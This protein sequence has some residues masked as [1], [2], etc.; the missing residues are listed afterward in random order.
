MKLISAILIDDELSCL[1][2]LQSELGKSCPE[3]KVHAL[4]QSAKEGLI[5]FNKIKPDLIFLDIDM[6]MIDGFE[7]L[8][9]LPPSH[10]ADIIFVTAFNDFAIKA[11]RVSAADY[12]LKPINSS[13]LKEALARIKAKNAA[14]QITDFDFL[15][16]QIKNLKGNGITKIALPTFNGISMVKI[17]EIN[18]CK[19]DSNYTYVYKSDGSNIL[20]TKSLSFID[21]LLSD[22]LFFRCHKSY[23]INLNFVDQVLK[24]NNIVVL[25]NER[26]PIS[27]RRKS[28]L[29]QL[30]SSNENINN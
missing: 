16:N 14:N 23:L 25:N 20:V 22:L 30:L 15:L 8:E 13:I 21:D 9:L 12:L 28:E 29:L 4:C 26:V 24:V 27:R 6:P 19:A 3:V 11:I 10:Q 1:E 5:A 18:Y 7:F 2:V 17:S